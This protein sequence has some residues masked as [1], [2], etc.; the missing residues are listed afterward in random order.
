MVAPLLTLL[1]MTALTG[2]LAD[3]IGARTVLCT[4]L[5]LTAPTTV[6]ADEAIS[7]QRLPP[8]L[9]HQPTNPAP[10]RT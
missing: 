5:L 9:P 4:G 2:A 1:A 7:A 8:R 10:A 6:P 3:R